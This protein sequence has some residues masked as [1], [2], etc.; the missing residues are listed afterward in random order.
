MPRFTQHDKKQYLA[1][2]LQRLEEIMKVT[3]SEVIVWLVVGALA[4]SLAGIIVTRK[5]EGFGRYANLGIG[6]IGALIGGF[7]FDL[8]NID[9]GLGNISVS[10]EDLASAFLGS[11]IFLAG[12]WYTLKLRKQKTTSK[13]SSTDNSKVP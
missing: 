5:K 2:M 12:L 13:I 6:L 3:L 4:G 10:F 9:L 11:L 8:L 1:K 7:I